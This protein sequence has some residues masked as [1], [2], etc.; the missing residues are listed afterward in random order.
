M[1]MHGFEVATAGLGEVHKEE[2]RLT[3]GL[4]DLAELKL[5]VL[6]GPKNEFQLFAIPSVEVELMQFN[7]S[8]VNEGALDED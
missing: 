3:D 4:Q 2:M 6:L 7:L 1:Q 8:Y 5:T